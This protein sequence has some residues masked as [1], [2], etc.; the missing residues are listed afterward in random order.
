MA[1]VSSDDGTCKTVGATD[2][3]RVA[4][5]GEEVF[6]RLAVDLRVRDIRSPPAP[7]H[8]PLYSPLYGG[9]QRGGLVTSLSPFTRKPN[10]TVLPG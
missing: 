3:S 10:H 9:V 4:G 2:R 6:E 7:D 8:I 1:R 5:V